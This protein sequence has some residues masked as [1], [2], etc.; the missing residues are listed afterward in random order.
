[1]LEHT[2][3]DPARYMESDEGIAIFLKHSLDGM[4]ENKDHVLSCLQA[5][6]KAWTVNHLAKDLDMDRSELF[7][8]FAIDIKPTES[9]IT[10]FIKVFTAPAP[11][12]VG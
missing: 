1:L 8:H 10:K 4:S 12:T 7:D 3:Y 6:I 9:T 11:Q 2:K 5:A